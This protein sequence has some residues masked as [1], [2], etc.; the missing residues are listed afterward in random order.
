MTKAL[1]MVNSVR[2][3]LSTMFPGF[4]TE[5]KHNHYRDFGFPDDVSFDLAYSMYRRNGIANAAIDKTVL[6]VWEDNP[7][8]FEEEEAHPETELERSIR[9]RFDSLR[10]WQKIS[11]ADRRSMV[12]AYSGVILRLADSKAFS[13]PVDRVP[14][15]LDGLVEIIPAWEGQ[16][17][18]SQWDTDERSPTYGLPLMF[19]FNESA[20]GKSKQPRSLQVHPDRVII[21]S[22]DSTLDGCSRLEAGY[23]DLMTMEKIAGA[24]GEGFW[25]AAKSSPILEIDEKTDIDRMAQTMG[26]DKSE[27]VDKMNA[28]VEDWQKGFDQMLMLQGIKASSPGV[29][30]PANPD[31]YF[32]VAL[33]SFAASFGIPLKVLTGSQTGERASTEDS[34]E[35]AKTNMARRANVVRPTIMTLVNRL[36]RFQIIPERDWYLGWADLTESSMPEKIERAEKMS[37]VNRNMPTTEEPVFSPDE[38]RE[39]V[40][41]KPIEIDEE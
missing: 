16:L 21:F 25:K 15:G 19:Q 35:W 11:E 13:D 30:L 7:S 38:I 2:R 14:G 28:Q 5:A 9:Q 4:F 6:K 8:L 36:E 27:I 1:T 37:K 40:G 32:M 22:A 34:D 20:F 29:T 17:E 41:L 3:S 12:G 18:A 33:E 10:L 26:V 24:G 23:N 31:K 39:V